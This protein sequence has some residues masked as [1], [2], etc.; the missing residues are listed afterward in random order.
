MLNRRAISRLQRRLEMRK[1]LVGCG[2]AVALF[3]FGSGPASAGGFGWDDSY[4]RAYYYGGYYGYGAPGYYVYGAPAVYGYAG[5]GPVYYV[6]PR[7]Y[8]PPVY[9]YYAPPSRYYYK[10][11]T[12]EYTG[13]RTYQYRPHYGRRYK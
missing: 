10:P 8:A 2:L 13:P 12:Y 6:A 11:T 9:T 5:S 3:A 4:P 7:Y 1:D